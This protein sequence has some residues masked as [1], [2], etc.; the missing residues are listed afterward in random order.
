MLDIFNEILSDPDLPVQEF[1]VTRRAEVMDEHGRAVHTPTDMP[2][3]GVIL[4]ATDK[5]LERLEDGDRSS[6]VI[7]VYSAFDLT[8]GSEGYAPDLVS[9]RGDTYEVKQLQDFVESAG[10]CVALAGSISMQGREPG[11]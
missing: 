10:F 8:N 4:P 11:E 5:Q 2:T 1:T 9:W 7:A 3:I 6:E